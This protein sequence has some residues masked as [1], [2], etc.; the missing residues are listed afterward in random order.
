V[1]ELKDSEVVVELGAIVVHRVLEDT[2]NCWQ[3]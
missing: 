3:K 1:V 2:P